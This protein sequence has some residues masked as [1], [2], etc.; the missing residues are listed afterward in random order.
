[1]PFAE[2]GANWCETSI[3]KQFISLPVG[4]WEGMSRDGWKE[5][6]ALLQKVLFL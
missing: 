1:M 2:H 5:V 6:A 4:F 3:Y